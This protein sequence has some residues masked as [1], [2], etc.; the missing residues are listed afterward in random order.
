MREPIHLDCTN[1]TFDVVRLGTLRDAEANI[2]PATTGTQTYLAGE[3]H[4][5]PDDAALIDQLIRRHPFVPAWVVFESKHIRVESVECYMRGSSLITCGQAGEYACAV[6]DGALTA[7][8]VVEPSPPR[9]TSEWIDCERA[10]AIRDLVGDDRP[11][12]EV[13]DGLQFVPFDPWAPE[14]VEAN[15]A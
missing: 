10:R 8:T 9:P 13:P 15:R 3:I 7:L 5:G 6:L 2:R 14:Y 12:V 4:C 1:Q 11:V